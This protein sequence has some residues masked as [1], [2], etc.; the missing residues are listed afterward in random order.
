MEPK[1]PN[2][3]VKL[4]G[5]DG[6]AFNIMGAV[7]KALRRAEVSKDE[8]SQYMAEAMSGDYDNLLQVTMKWVNV[9]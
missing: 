5:G 7:S 6:N 9:E 1:Y 2:I 4:I 3:S 8:V